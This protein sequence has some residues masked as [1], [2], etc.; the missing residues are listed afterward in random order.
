MA[1]ATGTFVWSGMPYAFTLSREHP[2]PRE[3]FR[4]PDGT[5]L[6]A[7]GWHQYGDGTYRDPDLYPPEIIQV[8]P[9]QVAAKLPDED[10]PVSDV[11]DFQS[12]SGAGL[13]NACCIGLN[14]VQAIELVR[15]SSTKEHTRVY[16]RSGPLLWIDMPY[17][18]ARKIWLEW[19]RSRQ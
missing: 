8:R 13:S 10:T 16:L 5:V 12:I 15:D 1:N 11:L 14:D 7:G 9:E 19:K 4:L 6:A 2:R 17:A 3:Y 18:T